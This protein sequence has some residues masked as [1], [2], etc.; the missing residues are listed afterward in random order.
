MIRLTLEKT[1]FPM[2]VVTDVGDFH[3]WPVTKYQFEQFMSESDKY[4]DKWYHSILSLNQP[5]PYNSF[6]EKNYE[7]LFMTGILPAEAIDFARWL[8]DHF[9]LPTGEEWK[10]FYCAI[11]NEVDIFLSPY[12]LSTPAIT[13]REKMAG[14]QRTP[15]KYSFLQEGIVEWVKEKKDK[16]Y[17]R[18]AGRGAP[19]ASF[20]PN[21]WN[22]LDDSIQVI[23]INQ[24]I[25]YFGF[26]LIRRYSKLKVPGRRR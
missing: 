9:D 13:I 8:G 23:N 18:F 10:K 15:L 26:R 22:P 20:F 1:G 14:F 6:S 21:T 11:N 12:G 3:L 2:A 4:D 7:R 17:N 24:R 19:R 16:E 5:I 25:F